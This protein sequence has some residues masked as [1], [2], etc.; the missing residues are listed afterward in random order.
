MPDYP[1]AAP[2]VLTD[3]RLTG[4][5]L[6]PYQGKDIVVRT[7]FEPATSTCAVS[8]HVG[9]V[10]GGGLGRMLAYR[11]MFTGYVEPAQVEDEI[12]Q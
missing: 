1:D 5:D 4:I 6:A 9:D 7:V 12:P 8:V 11:V 2:A 10:P 3:I